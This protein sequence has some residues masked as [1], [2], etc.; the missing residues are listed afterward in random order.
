MAKIEE[1]EALMSEKARYQTPID[2]E[3]KLPKLLIFFC[4]LY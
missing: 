3:G 4:F 1:K 2:R